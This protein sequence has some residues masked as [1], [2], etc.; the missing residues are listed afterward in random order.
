MSS[1]IKDQIF[2]F[3]KSYLNRTSQKMSGLE[4][5]ANFQ[6]CYQHVPFNRLKQHFE[7]LLLGNNSMGGLYSFGQSRLPLGAHP[8]PSQA[9]ESLSELGQQGSEGG[10]L[11]KRGRLSVGLKTRTESP[12]QVHV[13][14][15]PNRAKKLNVKKIQC[16]FEDLM[17]KVTLD[18]GSKIQVNFQ[19]TSP[20]NSIYVSNSLHSDNLS[21]KTGLLSQDG[22]DRRP[23]LD[24]APRDPPRKN[25]VAETRSTGDDCFVE[26]LIQNSHFGSV[27]PELVS[28][29][30]NTIR[31]LLLNIKNTFQ[32]ENNLTTTVKNLITFE[33]LQIRLGSEVFQKVPFQAKVAVVVRYWFQLVNTKWFRANFVEV[34]PSVQVHKPSFVAKITKS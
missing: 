10:L 34:L 1:E 26:C 13:Q 33:N 20:T 28:Q 27:Q 16:D 18:T 6:L 12:V 14:L 15:M 8:R 29:R 11:A 19:T 3:V 25:R 32:F 7:H 21:L 24:S 4:I 30:K 9:G 23:L 5:Q 22:W 31:K 2:A 17:S